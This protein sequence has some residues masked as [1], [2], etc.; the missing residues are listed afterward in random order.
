MAETI[1]EPWLSGT[2]TGVPPVLRAVLHALEL[3][4]N[5]LHYFSATLTDEELNTRPFGLPPVTFH[6]KH[7]ARS[8]DRL[9]TY[10]EGRALGEDQLSAIQTELGVVTTKTELFAELDAAIAR[11]RDAHSRV[12]CG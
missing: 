4:R 7:I 11:K 3:A 1:P 5:D 6:L 8:L 9:L 2:L 12:R 10:A